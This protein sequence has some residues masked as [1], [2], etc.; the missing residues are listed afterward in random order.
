MLRNRRIS[1][2]TATK[3]TLPKISISHHDQVLNCVSRCGSSW[4]RSMCLP[5]LLWTGTAMC[6]FWTC[7]CI[8]LWT[9]TAMCLFWTCYCILLWTGTA[10]CLFWTCYCILLWT[11]T[12]MCLF[13][14]C[15]CILLWTGTAM[16]L[17]W[18]CYCILLWTGTAMCLFWTCYCI[19]FAANH[20]EIKKTIKSKRWSKGKYRI[21]TLWWLSWEFSVRPMKQ[22]N[23]NC[24]K[25]KAGFLYDKIFGTAAVIRDTIT[26]SVRPP[27]SGTR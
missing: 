7:Y 6:L 9:G 24:T 16:C 3:P 5:A 26:F 13:W 21:S 25:G 20:T 14:T 4:S 27:W 23:L 15:Y 8:P 22:G 18:T 10:M 17:F 2:Q 12:A 19:L 1:T 11:G